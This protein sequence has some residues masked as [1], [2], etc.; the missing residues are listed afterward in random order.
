MNPP[1]NSTR[2]VL[3]SFILDQ[4]N[5]RLLNLFSPLTLLHFLPCSF[6]REREGIKTYRSE[7][8]S[9]S[10]AAITFP[11][12]L[13]NQKRTLCNVKTPWGVVCQSLMWSKM[14]STQTKKYIKIVNLFFIVTKYVYSAST[15][16]N[17]KI[18]KRLRAKLLG[19]SLNI[20][21]L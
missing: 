5:W 18:I 10:Q 3:R 8:L 2:C 21:T 4:W 13:T 16:K 19:H 9:Y 1:I 17:V 12:V 14:K 15:S 11:F 20:W 6:L 7:I